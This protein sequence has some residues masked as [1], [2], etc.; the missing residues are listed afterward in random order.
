[1]NTTTLNNTFASAKYIMQIFNLY[2]LFLF[3]FI[4]VIVVLFL[5]NL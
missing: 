3:A 4:M 1:M 2:D 5:K